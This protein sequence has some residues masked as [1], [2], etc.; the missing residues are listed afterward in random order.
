[1]P[2]SSI[3][4][5]DVLKACCRGQ[6]ESSITDLAN[7]IVQL[8]EDE[9]SILS[10]NKNNNTDKEM[11]GE[12]A[13][14]CSKLLADIL[15]T[16]LEQQQQHDNNHDDDDDDNIKA[17]VHGFV[18]A[19]WLLTCR[20]EGSSSMSTSVLVSVIQ[21]V[22]ERTANHDNVHVLLKTEMLKTIGDCKLLQSTGIIGKD[23]D[24][25]KKLRM[26]NTTVFY[27]QHKFNLLAE[28]S[29]AAAADFVSSSRRHDYYFY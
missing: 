4:K 16:L 19:I 1:M 17:F 2:Q 29:A 18:N 20:H 13:Q 23:I 7:L 5:D 12:T 14:A 11:K 8:L 26:T 15:E 6:E 21:T 27:C 9:I 28:E 25:P 10:F 22:L 3:S 24:L